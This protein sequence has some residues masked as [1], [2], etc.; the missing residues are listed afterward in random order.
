M[1]HWDEKYSVGILSIDG[2][3]K[4]LFAHLNHLLEVM[5]TGSAD[6]ILPQIITDLERYAI[7]HFQKEE[8]F[9]QRFE[10][11]GAQEHILEHQ[12]FIEKIADFKSGLKTRKLSLSIELL[13]FLKEWIEHH[14]MVSDKAYSECFRQNGL[15]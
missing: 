13:Q 4:E 9:F 1:I 5:K 6:E 12:L 2:Q 11:S 15:K 7:Q 10:Y 3:H 8:F 14:I